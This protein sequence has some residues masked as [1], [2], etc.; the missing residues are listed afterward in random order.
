M[1][2]IPNFYSLKSYGLTSIFHIF[3]PLKRYVFSVVLH[4]FYCLLDSA[5]ST[6]CYLPKTYKFLFLS[7]YAISHKNISL[8]FVQQ[9]HIF[10][11]VT[12]C[13]FCAIHFL[14]SVHI[15]SHIYAFYAYIPTQYIAFFNSI[16]VKYI[17]LYR[18]FPLQQ[19]SYIFVC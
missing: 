2:L 18:V 19:V 1:P 14:Y 15:F 6:F 8:Y 10:S 3:L 12:A 13:H 4:S 7:L 9:I 17:R 16:F 5:L 11:S